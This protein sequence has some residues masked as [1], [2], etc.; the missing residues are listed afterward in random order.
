MSTRFVKGKKI[1]NLINLIKHNNQMDCLPIHVSI[2]GK[3]SDYKKINE[4]I[5]ILKLGKYISLKTL[6]SERE[7][8]KWNSNLFIYL[9]FSEGETL[10][11]S[12]IRALR[13]GTPIIASNTTGIKEM[14][15]KKNNLNGYLVNDKKYIQILKLIKKIL[16]DKKLYNKLSKNSLKLFKNRYSLDNSLYKYNKLINSFK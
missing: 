15:G 12:I 11:T 4:Y 1:F 3:G 7:L 2:I 6:L 16:E 13:A 10:S 5:K 8:N 14:I 9:H